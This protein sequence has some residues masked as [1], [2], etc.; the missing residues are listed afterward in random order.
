M[1]RQFIIRPFRSYFTRSIFLTVLLILSMT[2]IVTAQ[3]FNSV[4]DPEIRYV[5]SL[6]EKP[7]FRVEYNTQNRNVI[8]LS[9]TDEEGRLLYSD[10]LN[11]QFYLKNFQVDADQYENFKLFLTITDTNI[12]SKEKKRRVY[13]INGKVD[14][15]SPDFGVTK[16]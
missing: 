6:K 3:T 12:D 16:L 10:K 11:Q 2:S 4:S 1:K 5:G 14:T 9:I 8:E 13:L 15:S 7:V